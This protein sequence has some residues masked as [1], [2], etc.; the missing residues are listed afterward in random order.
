MNG[1]ERANTNEPP[2]APTRSPEDVPQDLLTSQERRIQAVV[3]RIW[4]RTDYSLGTDQRHQELTEGFDDTIII[5]LGSM[6]HIFNDRDRYQFDDSDP[7]EAIYAFFPGLLTCNINPYTD[8]DTY[9]Y[10]SQEVQEFLFPSFMNDKMRQRN[11]QSPLFIADK[12]AMRTGYLLW[13]QPDQYGRP[14]QQNRIQPWS[15]G[16]AA[17]SEG[18]KQRD[19]VEDG[20][21]QAFGWQEGEKLVHPWEPPS[22]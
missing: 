14:L 17:I 12:E 11:S 13:L 18:E 2:P 7:S 3:G 15:L 4:L 8:W 19:E 20:I 16:E 1:W 21:M 22:T 10:D 9:S 6:E 5:P